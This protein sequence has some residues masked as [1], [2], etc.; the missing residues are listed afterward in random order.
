M[1]RIKEKKKKGVG[2]EYELQFFQIIRCSP[3]RQGPDNISKI[4]NIIRSDL[5][6]LN[7]IS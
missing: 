5:S 4:Y 1:G 2:S 7:F 6:A 3:T